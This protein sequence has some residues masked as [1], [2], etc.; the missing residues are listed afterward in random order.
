MGRSC[1]YWTPPRGVAICWSIRVLAQLR[2]S[3]GWFW[4]L[5]TVQGCL[6]RQDM[7]L[8]TSFKTC[9]PWFWLWMRSQASGLTSHRH[10]HNTHGDVCLLNLLCMTD[11]CMNEI[12]CLHTDVSGI[13]PHYRLMA[14]SWIMRPTHQKRG[15]RRTIL[16]HKPLCFTTDPTVW[17]HFTVLPAWLPP[18]HHYPVNPNWKKSSTAF[19]GTVS[20]TVIYH[21]WA[22]WVI[23]MACILITYFDIFNDA[24]K[25]TLKL[26]RCL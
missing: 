12:H 21:P 13:F 3:P 17:T 7:I 11:M 18:Y 22:H 23:L 15:C 5:S 10:P 24:I 19:Q 4:A 6:I 25:R 2:S 9:L 1:H 8:K 20:S 14:W 16:H 26:S